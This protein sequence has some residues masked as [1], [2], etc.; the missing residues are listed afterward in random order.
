MTRR[1][2]AHPRKT[3]AIWSPCPLTSTYA[4]YLISSLLRKQNGKASKYIFALLS[5]LCAIY[6]LSTRSCLQVQSKGP[7]SLFC[8]LEIVVVA[9]T[10]KDKFIHRVEREFCLLCLLS[11]LSVALSLG[12]VFFSLSSS[13]GVSGR[14]PTHVSSLHASGRK[15]WRLFLKREC[16]LDFLFFCR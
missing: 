11:H 4:V 12:L 10:Q 7:Q 1:L 8:G 2:G 6:W 3:H 9:S 13:M 16:F 14:N 15:G 5:E